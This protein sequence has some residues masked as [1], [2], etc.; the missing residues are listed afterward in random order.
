[1]TIVNMAR[2]DRAVQYRHT[3]DQCGEPR[4]CAVVKR[5]ERRD[6]RLCRTCFKDGFWKETP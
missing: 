6:L 4:L 3:C 5:R 2:W 1:V